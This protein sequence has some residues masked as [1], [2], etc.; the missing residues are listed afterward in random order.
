MDGMCDT[1]T[2]GA[3]KTLGNDSDV[4]SQRDSNVASQ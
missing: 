3:E 2:Y 4:A 1:S